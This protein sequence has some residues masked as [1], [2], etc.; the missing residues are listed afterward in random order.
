MFDSLKKVFGGNAIAAFQDRVGDINALEPEVKELSD[1]AFSSRSLELKKRAMEGESL[2]D[3]LVAGGI[4][5][6][7][8]SG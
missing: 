2:D 4:C 1:E 8:R 5:A 7:P 6:C 3:I